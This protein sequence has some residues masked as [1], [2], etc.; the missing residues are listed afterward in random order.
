MG[1]PP[2][3]EPG[4]SRTTMYCPPMARHPGV[5][6]W[7]AILFP[8]E[9]PF[10]DVIGLSAFS[11]LPLVGYLDCQRLGLMSVKL[12]LNPSLG[13][14]S[15]KL[16][17]NPSLMSIFLYLGFPLSSFVHVFN[18]LL[19]NLHAYVND[20]LFQASMFCPRRFFC[21]FVFC[22][23]CLFLVVVVVVF[24]FDDAIYQKRTKLF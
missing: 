3:F 23:F 13:L 2:G 6:A 5:A 4:A 8:Y 7:A 1:V 19:K 20:K 15:V 17:L 12:A 14:M 18:F 22:F 10:Y 21:F 11:S 9:T 16:A 24:N